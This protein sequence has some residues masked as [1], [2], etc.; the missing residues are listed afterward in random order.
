MSI[1]LLRHI[2]FAANEAVRLIA[3]RISE[4]TEYWARAEGPNLVTNAPRKLIKKAVREAGLR[5]WECA[6]PAGFATEYRNLS[7]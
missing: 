4:T 1:H 3:L 6:Q 5:S 2:D 7:R